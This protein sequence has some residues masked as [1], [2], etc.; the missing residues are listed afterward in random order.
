[1]GVSGDMPMKTDRR[2]A[3]TDAY[4]VSDGVLFESPLK[5]IATYFAVAA[6]WRVPNG[7]SERRVG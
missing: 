2:N 7:R 6:L 1:M 3:F 5:A 4:F